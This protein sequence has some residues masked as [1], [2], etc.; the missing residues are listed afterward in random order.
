MGSNLSFLAIDL[1]TASSSTRASACAVGWA[2]VDQGELVASGSRRIQPGIPAPDWGAVNIRIHGIRPESVVEAAAFTEVW[3]EVVA[4]RQSL[5]LVAHNASFDM[6]VLRA[7]FG[8]SGAG[9]G[10]LRYACSLV[11]AKAIWPNLASHSLPAVA[12]ALRFDLH[13]HEPESDAVACAKIVISAAQEIGA[14]SLDETLDRA[15]LHWGWI[16]SASEW[17]PC[18]GIRFFRK[19]TGSSSANQST[20]A[21]LGNEQAGLAALDPEHPFFA[22]NI[23]F[24]GALDSMPRAIAER[25]VKQL[26]GIPKGSVTAT[27]GFLIVGGFKDSSDLVGVPPTSGKHRK[28]LAL[29]RSGAHVQLMSE[30]DFL[31]LL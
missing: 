1:E 4:D 8:R 26:G 28:A 21:S 30:G 6:S 12:S 13:H 7:E 11:L 15:G 29:Q 27:T 2:A 10:Q 23:V 17:S 16:R 3:R 9:F 22:K 18:T 25:F 31:A 20:S 19:D 14:K 24:T 5:P